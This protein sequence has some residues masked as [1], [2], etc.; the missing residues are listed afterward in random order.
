MP[1]TAVWRFICDRLDGSTATLE[2]RPPEF[3]DVKAVTREQAA[4]KTDGG[5]RY[6][7]DFGRSTHRYEATWKNL[8]RCERA[9]ME[10]FFGPAGTMAQARPFRIEIEGDPETAFGISADLGLSADEEWDADDLVVADGPRWGRVY[11]AQSR[12]AFSLD[13]RDGR[14]GTSLLFDM[15]D[16]GAALT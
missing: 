4:A 11:L 14:Y 16:D 7:Q 10:V 6:V 9:D 2:I 5:Q 15:E 12:L 3:G 13:A 8:S 1:S